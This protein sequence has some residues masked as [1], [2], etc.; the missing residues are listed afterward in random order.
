MKVKS[1]DSSARY[2]PPSRTLEIRTRKGVLTT[3]A[4]ASTSYEFR[5]KAQVPTDLPIE[6]GISID[7]HRLNYPNLLEFLRSNGYTNN[8][9]KKIDLAN[10]LAQYSQIRIALIQP[11]TSE[12]TDVKTRQMKYPSGMSII[13]NDSAQLHNFLSIL[14]KLQLAIGLDFIA[15][16]FL[17]LPL[18]TMKEVFRDVDKTMERAGSQPLFVL[19]MKHQDFSLILDFLVEDLRSNMIGLIYRDYLRNIHSY[20]RVYKYAERDV[21]F[22]S[23]HVERLDENN[24]NLSTMH[25]LPFLTNDIYSVETPTFGGVNPEKRKEGI[26]THRLD[27]VKLFDKQ[28]LQIN[29]ITSIPNL[30]ERILTEYGDDTIVRDTLENYREA[31]TDNKKIQTLAA[32]S[33]I[34]ELRLS[35]KEFLNLQRFINQD[36]ARDYISEKKTLE[37]ALNPVARSRLNLNSF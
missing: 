3:P 4:R 29:K 21:A 13:Q 2:L 26:G 20:E 8:L 22:F 25:C 36:S 12:T 35:S 23:M 30:Q 28:S 24:D 27:R 31:E 34:D 15:I 17:H 10:R 32:F 16:P 37:K 5:Q 9:I 33:K 19:D 18:T 7:I 1:I 14:V 11:T 6:N